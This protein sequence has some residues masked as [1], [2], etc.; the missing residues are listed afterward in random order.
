MKKFAI[1][2][3]AI[4]FLIPA[5]QAEAFLGDVQIYFVNQDIEIGAAS[6]DDNGFGVRGRLFFTENFF[7]TARFQRVSFDGFDS[8]DL[9]V[10]G[11]WAF[12]VSPE[13]TPYVKVEYIDLGSDLDQDGFG[14]T[15]GVDWSVTPQFILR[16]E[17]GYIDLDDIDGFELTAGGT[18]MFTPTLG[19]F[20]EVR[21]WDA[22]VNGLDVEITDIRAGVTFNF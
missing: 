19:A 3:V 8:D 1:L 9:R 7:G 4:G 5:A 16:G 21:W 12:R 17:V 13:V 18:F 10:G 15:G 14:V 6:D 11:G 2:A 22:S 20:A